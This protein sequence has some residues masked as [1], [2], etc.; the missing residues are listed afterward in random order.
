MPEQDAKPTTDRAHSSVFAVDVKQEPSFSRE[1]SARARRLSP[2]EREEIDKQRSADAYRK[3]HEAG[4]T[5]EFKGDMA[6]LA[7][8]KKRRDELAA[9]KKVVDDANERAA[10][11]AARTK[12]EPKVTASLGGRNDDDD[13]KLDKRTVKGLKPDAIKE[14]LKRLGLS[15]QGTKAEITKRLL[16]AL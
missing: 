3:K 6:R 5:D 8:A 13:E 9:K 14:H 1:H 7:V 12:E 15:S 2:G 10:V 11:G 4:N 16:E